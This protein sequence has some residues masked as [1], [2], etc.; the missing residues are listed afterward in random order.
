M[1]ILVLILGS[2]TLVAGGTAIT[3]QQDAHNNVTAHQRPYQEHRAS[4]R[5]NCPPVATPIFDNVAYPLTIDSCEDF[6]IGNQDVNEDGTVD[7]WECYF[8]RN[9]GPGCKDSNVNGHRADILAQYV[10][11]SNP[12]EVK[13]ESF[14]D[15]NPDLINYQG[16][17]FI[18][19]VSLSMRGHLDVTGDGKPDAIIRANYS[20]ECGQPNIV[21]QYFYIENIFPSAACATDINNDGSTTVNDLI[22]VVANWGACP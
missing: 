10:P 18:Y 19:S 8:W 12:P 6:F 17:D 11:G 13:L 15:L 9:G 4:S 7:G 2:T 5:G 3:S 16:H 14:L 21:E 22:A 1:K 20:T